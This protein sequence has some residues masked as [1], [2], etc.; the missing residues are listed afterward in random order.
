MAGWKPPLELPDLRNCDLVAVDTETD[1]E[2][3]REDKGSGWPMRQGRI[4]LNP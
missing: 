4:I 1:D 3:L 2:R